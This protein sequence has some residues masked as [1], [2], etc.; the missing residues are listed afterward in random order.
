MKRLRIGAHYRARDKR[1]GFDIE[2][3]F[4]EGKSWKTVGKLDGPFAGNSKYFVFGDVPAGAKAALV[5]LTG[6]QI[7][8][9]GIHDLRIDADYLEAHG[10]FAPVKVTYAWAE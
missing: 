3:S 10:E 7:N 1:D 6:V 5:R 8:T 2:A 4:D 9:T